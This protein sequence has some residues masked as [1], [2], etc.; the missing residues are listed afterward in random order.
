MLLFG[1]SDIIMSCSEFF[2]ES[3]FKFIRNRITFFWFGVHLGQD[4]E[5]AIW[6]FISKE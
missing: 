4:I 5:E 2:P 3:Y 1:H 6:F